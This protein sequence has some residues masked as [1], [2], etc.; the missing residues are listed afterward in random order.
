M[1]RLYVPIHCLN[2][3]LAA[4]RVEASEGRDPAG[5]RVLLV[6]ETAAQF[7]ELTSV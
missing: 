6:G 3:A 5:A 7:L 1:T 4:A 2:A